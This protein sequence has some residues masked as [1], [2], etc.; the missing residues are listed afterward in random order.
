[1]EAFRSGIH[2]TARQRL[3]PLSSVLCGIHEFE[4]S[5]CGARGA[6]DSSDNLLVFVG[7]RVWA[8]RWI[9][10]HL[11][12][13]HRKDNPPQKKNKKKTSGLTGTINWFSRII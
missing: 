3:A 2:S 13:L 4:V 11:A 7:A 12:V 9:W 8:A 10:G 6:P 1:M 5:V